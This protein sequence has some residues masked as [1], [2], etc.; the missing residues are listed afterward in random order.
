[1]YFAFRVADV[2]DESLIPTGWYS[3]CIVRSNVR[4]LKSGDGQRLVLTYALQDGPYANRRVDAGFNIDHPNPKVVEISQKELAKV[5]HACGLSVIQDTLEL[6]D[7]PHQIH[8]GVETYQSREQNRITDWRPLA[9]A[10]VPNAATA[11]APARP[12]PA[13]PATAAV[14]HPASQAFQAPPAPVAAPPINGR[15]RPA[16]LPP[17]A[18]FPASAASAETAAPQNGIPFNDDIPW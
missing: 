11:P 8:I 13:A 5:L 14:R 1:M 10:V 16:P 9:P 18:P 15:S 3:A 7:R 4:E 2:P 17:A 6:H 12:A